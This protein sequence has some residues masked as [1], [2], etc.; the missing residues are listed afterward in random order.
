MTAI[1]HL[2][3]SPADL[4]IP[5]DHVT[6][7]EVY[8]GT[9]GKL[10][11]HIQD[12]HANY[13]GQRAI[14]AAL[15]RLMTSTG[16]CL[17]LAEGASVDATLTEAKKGISDADWKIAAR[18]F[19]QVGVIT[20]IEYLNLTSNHPMTLIGI[21]DRGLYDRALAAYGDLVDERKQILLYLRQIHI[22]M[23]RLKNRLY[24]TI[25][26]SYEAKT[27]NEESGN[28]SAQDSLMQRFDA[29]MDLVKSASLTLD[30]YPETQK[31]LLLKAKEKSLNFE[32]ANLEQEKLLADL[33]SKGLHE[34]VQSFTENAGRMRQSQ[35]SQGAMLKQLFSLAQTNGI[36]TQALSELSSYAEYL[37][38][39]ASLDIEGMLKEID[40]LEDAAYK[41]LLPEESPRVLRAIDRFLGILEKAYSIQMSSFDFKMLMANK[42]DFKT[43]NWQGF[44]NEQ[45][46]Q[47]DYF[48]DLVPYKTHFEDASEALLRFY[49]VVDE[50]DEAF[51]R[52]TRKALEAKD[53]KLG[54]LIAGGY[55]TENLTRLLKK[56][57][58]SIAVLTPNVTDETNQSLY[59]KI[60]LL[61]L[62]LA[63]RDEEKM[64][65]RL[66]HVSV[67]EGP[68]RST[69]GSRLAMGA[70]RGE[71]LARTA[72]YV[73]NVSLKAPASAL[74]AGSRISN[75]EEGARLATAGAGLRT[76]LQYLF[77]VLAEAGSGGVQIQG[78]SIRPYG[79][80]D[81]G[82]TDWVQQTDAGRFIN[83][84][85][86][87]GAEDVDEVYRPLNFPNENELVVFI[88]PK[89]GNPFKKMG[90][91]EQGGQAE[92]GVTFFTDPKDVHGMSLH[93]RGD[94]N[95]RF[96]AERAYIPA[97]V[98][99][100][101]TEDGQAIRFMTHEIE[102]G[103]YQIEV[104]WPHGI[105]YA[106]KSAAGSPQSIQWLFTSSSKLF[107]PKKLKGTDKWHF[108]IDGKPNTT[109]TILFEESKNRVILIRVG[110]SGIPTVKDSLTA[111]KGAR[112]AAANPH[113]RQFR[114][115]IDGKVEFVAEGAITDRIYQSIIVAV[116][117][118]LSGDKK[119]LTPL[120]IIDAIDD[121]V[122][123]ALYENSGNDHLDSTSEGLAHNL[124]A[125]ALM[126]V[127]KG[128]PV[129]VVSV[130]GPTLMYMDIYFRG[131]EEAYGMSLAE[132]KNVPE[133][134]VLLEGL[135][136]LCVDR[137]MRD[138]MATKEEYEESARHLPAGFDRPYEAASDRFRLALVS[139][140][141]DMNAR[142][143]GTKALSINL[144]HYIKYPSTPENEANTEFD[145][146][147]FDNEKLKQLRIKVNKLEALAFRVKSARSAKRQDKLLGELH[148]EMRLLVDD[149]GDASLDEVWKETLDVLGFD[150]DSVRLGYQVRKSELSKVPVLPSAN[151]QGQSRMA[152][153]AARLAVPQQDASEVLQENAMGSRMAKSKGNKSKIPG[154]GKPHAANQEATRIHKAKAIKIE[155]WTY[156]LGLA[157]LIYSYIHTRVIQNDFGLEEYKHIPF[158]VNPLFR[159]H[160]GDFT[161]AFGYAFGL[162]VLSAIMVRSFQSK[163]AG[164]KFERITTYGASALVWGVLFHHEI[165]RQHD[166]PDL[167]V[168]SAAIAGFVM[169]RNYVMK[170]GRPQD[171]FSDK[172]SFRERGPK[173]SRMSSQTE[174]LYA[175][176]GLSSDAG[177]DE[178]KKAYKKLAR[179]WHPD[180][181]EGDEKDRYQEKLAL[182][183]H[184]RDVLSDPDQKYLYDLRRMV[185]NAQP[186]N[187]NESWDYYSGQGS[188]TRGYGFKYFVTEWVANFFDPQ[189]FADAFSDIFDAPL[190]H[191]R[192]RDRVVEQWRALALFM[193]HP[194][195]LLSA[196][197]LFAV[198]QASSWRGGA[199]DRLPKK[200]RIIST[201][202]NLKR[203]INRAAHNIMKRGFK[204]PDGVR[205][206]RTGFVSP[207]NHALFIDL[208]GR[209]EGA[210]IITADQSNPN[211]FRSRFLFDP[212]SGRRVRDLSV[213]LLKEVHESRRGRGI[214][215]ATVRVVN[216]GVEGI[217][218]TPSTTVFGYE[219]LAEDELKKEALIFRIVYE[220]DLGFKYLARISP[221]QNWAEISRTGG[222][223]AGSRMAD[224]AYDV[225]L[226]APRDYA[227][228]IMG[229]QQNAVGSDLPSDGDM[230]L[231]NRLGG[232][233]MAG[234]KLVA[235]NGARFAIPEEKLEESAGLIAKALGYLEENPVNAIKKHSQIMER[236]FS[237][238]S[239]VP[240]GFVYGLPIG[241]DRESAFDKARVLTDAAS[242]INYFRAALKINKE[243]KLFLTEA[244]ENHLKNIIDVTGIGYDSIVILKSESDLKEY[245]SNLL[246]FDIESN[247]NS[248]AEGAHFKLPIST[249]NNRSSTSWPALFAAAADTA[250]LLRLNGN[251]FN[252]NISD[253]IMRAQGDLSGGA[254]RHFNDSSKIVSLGVVRYLEML[255]K[256]TLNQLTT[257]KTISLGQ[258]FAR[259]L[260]AMAMVATA[261]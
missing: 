260:L 143:R 29:L 254:A 119:V 46:L 205:I 191:A 179:L 57:G 184:A 40:F 63:K 91:I 120:D 144:Y 79:S 126:Y 244:D 125:L 62:K 146:A 23:D 251:E 255:Q 228:E 218:H 103:V 256:G 14:A 137:F 156:S 68:N 117:N 130:G 10:I 27:K 121:V 111:P 22:S 34:E 212:E 11:I 192:V 25:L 55:H 211:T 61:P 174:D 189:S 72:P 87:D 149:V 194:Y 15:D 83:L 165:L 12:P 128:L 59:E 90:G 123:F 223:P 207:G 234:A 147:G 17:V 66:A 145:K 152:S 206:L 24:P 241:W 154:R 248:L 159:N 221:Y 122:R 201:E 183:N 186:G 235:A 71:M 115:R 246:I 188:P 18:R 181:A 81:W 177:P 219:T 229:T 203:E 197:I 36:D 118:K 231:L 75:R 217:F 224:D 139:Y 107:P 78:G 173:G 38:A 141:L 227:R 49:R 77:N 60:L 199:D 236:S 114:Q 19:L 196:V 257:I 9:N 213:S 210:D 88:D 3:S 101:F 242:A 4:D 204:V 124:R 26:R 133:G 168:E 35:L 6:L 237:K 247:G 226:K 176:L 178:I 136:L 150:E 261:A 109:H 48:D 85:Y 67:G 182:I 105:H 73:G 89:G 80:K 94:A 93:F 259:T 160:F 58:Y 258:Q 208:Q 167:A 232:V 113:D 190:G 175:V 53:A 216:A 92:K 86:I 41:A 31:L 65:L 163:V 99:I 7:K 214:N 193:M 187:T 96:E 112:M 222:G 70:T 170:H 104:Y 97:A 102:A 116:R 220:D 39:F 82:G 44:I 155:A 164:L 131:A 134:Q 110:D 142:R 32:H 209:I 21:E 76:E 238:V 100:Y 215:P 2:I 132:V 151:V 166:F 30:G 8:S 64:E 253:M 52:N 98:D 33:K 249:A 43:Q 140:L 148:A 171:M 16:Q 239:E 95:R 198:L 195:S 243:L 162:Y 138:N 69:L 106:Y 13:S 108:S 135:R 202:N 157:A 28:G 1:S 169:L 252:G 185:S 54:Y 250:G 172:L 50:R 47:L 161:S 158:I 225:G 129:E 240:M 51:V 37:Q 200:P 233:R 42:D 45:L 56:E 127:K 180:K 153:E 20:G 230:V 84:P 245:S 74:V 5:F